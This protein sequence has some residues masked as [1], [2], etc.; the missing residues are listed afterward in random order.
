MLSVPVMG[1]DGIVP[2]SESLRVL[3]WLAEQV[4]RGKT[5]RFVDVV[6]LAYG[7][8][9]SPGDDAHTEQLR[10]LLWDLA[11]HGVLIVASAGNE[12]S[13]T[14][15]YPAAFAADPPA[16]AVTVTSVG[17]TNPDGSYAHYSDFGDWVTHRAVGSGVISTITEFDGP[18]PA[19]SGWR[20]RCPSARPSTRTI[21]PPGSR[22]G[23]GHPSPPPRSSACW[24]LRSAQARR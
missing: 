18:Q 23:A 19:R 9:R 7:Y 20:F 13:P 10:E 11:D 6:C 21:S 15:T 4:H 5:D 12:G 1:N 24:P 3:A 2:A 16:P 22:A 14:P 17:A 8:V